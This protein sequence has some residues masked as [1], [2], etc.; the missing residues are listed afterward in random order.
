MQKLKT[1]LKRLFSAFTKERKNTLG[2]SLIELL[3]VIA[4][5]GVLAAVAIPA[6]NGYRVDA[7]KKAVETSL[8]TVGK[9]FSACIT[10]K[11]WSDCL[12]VDDMDVSCPDCD[13]ASTVAMGSFC[14]EVEK[15]IGG[16]DYRGCLQTTGG[17]PT[18]VNNWDKTPDCSKL[19]DTFH[20]VGA[21]W[22]NS[23][24][25]ANTGCTPGTAATGTCPT[26]SKTVACAAGTGTMAAMANCQT[27]SGFCN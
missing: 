12:T 23:M 11:E 20:C 10:L 5:I 3:V 24:T 2:F 26:A 16:D 15:E 19:R 9:G 14:I 18:I 1:F 21:T 6:Y 25:C 13:M 8:Q 17:I 7:G 22:T 4:I 27:S